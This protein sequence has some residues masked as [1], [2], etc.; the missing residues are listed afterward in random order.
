VL[1]FVVIGRETHDEG[2][3][4]VA[5]LETAAPFLLGLAVGWGVARIWL[6]PAA[7]RRGVMVVA[8]TLVFGM[9][10]RRLVFDDGTA[11]TFVLVTA[12]FLTLGMLGWRLVFARTGQRAVRT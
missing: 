9:L 12:G 8:A 7:L 2:N 4:I 6:A 11:A 3:A 10:T 1:L 5:T